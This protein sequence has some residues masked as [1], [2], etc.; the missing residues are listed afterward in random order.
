MAIA[1]INNIECYYEVHG[2][3]KPL[4]LIGGL[5]S[6]S[7]TWQL[8]LSPLKK[9]FKVIIF[10]NRAAGRTKDPGGAFDVAVM[11]KDAVMLLD[12]LGIE[13]ADILGHSMGGFIAQDIAAVYPERVNRLV[14]A[15]TAAALSG[16]VKILLGDLLNIYTN[17]AQYEAFIKEFMKWLFTPQFLNNKKKTDQFIKYV[18]AYSYRQTP[19]DFKRQFEACAK[20]HSVD[21]LKKIQSETLLLSG[22]QDRIVSHSEIDLLESMIP[23]TKTKRSANAAHSIQTEFPKQFVKDIIEFLA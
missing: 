14:L 17:D 8:V 15:N 12:H 5:S 13:N 19:E 4:L 18:L 10:D 21:R 2:E 3:G 20:Y 11:T 23:N 1:K 6:D 9:R 22:E 16:K 7:Q